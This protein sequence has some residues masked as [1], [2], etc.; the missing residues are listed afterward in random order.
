MDFLK[1]V[2]NQWGFLNMKG[3]CV[4]CVN[5]G[6]V[7]GSGCQLLVG[8]RDL[9]FPKFKPTDMFGRV[10]AG[11]C[12]KEFVFVA[13][14]WPV[15][16]R[17]SCNVTLFVFVFSFGS[18]LV[19]EGCDWLLAIRCVMRVFLLPMIERPRC[20]VVAV[21]VGLHDLVVS[22]FVMNRWGVCIFVCSVS[23]YKVHPLIFENACR[24]N[25]EIHGG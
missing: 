13:C 25:V 5:V 12:Q 10:V 21:T 24:A 19:L 18:V 17:Q 4:K 11:I 3:S 22:F 15:P 8:N 9:N 20:V 14:V 16:Q 23:V 1:L 2:F 7:N 6:S